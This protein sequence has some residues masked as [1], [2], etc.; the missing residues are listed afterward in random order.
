MAR[1]AH[2][3]FRRSAGVDGVTTSRAREHEVSGT[4]FRCVVLPDLSDLDGHVTDGFPRRRTHGGAQELQRH[5]DGS[6]L[7]SHSSKWSS[8][9]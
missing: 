8:Q 2:D 4:A 5:V 1:Q 9:L 3:A 6:T 7:G